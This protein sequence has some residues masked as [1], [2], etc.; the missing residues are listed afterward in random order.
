MGDKSS[1]DNQKIFKILVTGASGF[2]G[3][4][5]CRH[6]SKLGADVHATSRVM[7][8]SAQGGP[9][10]WHSTLIEI[11]S[12]QEIFSK[13]RPD[14]VYHLAGSVGAS[15]DKELVLPTFHSLLTSTVNILIGA[16][17]VGCRRVILSGSLTE[18]CSGNFSPTER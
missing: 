10:W 4:H 8:T 9:C 15:T 17:E 12:V 18:P 16:T 1:F 3:S 5:L 7:R 13:V 6:L 2:I 11:D 14:V